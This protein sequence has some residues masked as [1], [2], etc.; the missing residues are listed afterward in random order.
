MQSLQSFVNGRISLNRALISIKS[1]LNGTQSYCAN[2]IINRP[3]P[4]KKTKRKEKVAL[5]SKISPLG[6]PTVNVTPVLDRWVESGKK[7][8]FAELL[9]IIHDLRKRNR[10]SHAL[11]VLLTSSLHTF[12]ATSINIANVCFLYECLCF[13]LDFCAIFSSN[14]RNP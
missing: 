1:R 10:F 2:Q 4:E 3:K 13:F 8:R 7:L 5:Y 9:R 14:F 12:I 6:S 11:Q